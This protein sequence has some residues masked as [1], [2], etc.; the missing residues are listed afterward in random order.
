MVGDLAA[1]ANVLFSI[2]DFYLDYIQVE[3]SNICRSLS[4]TMKISLYFVIGVQFFK[5]GT[6]PICPFHIVQGFAVVGQKTDFMSSSLS[7]TYVVLV[8]QML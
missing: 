6:K 1:E 7:S 3:S 4:S 2:I 5:M 8:K